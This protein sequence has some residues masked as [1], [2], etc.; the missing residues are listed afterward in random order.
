MT[1]NNET[2]F[3]IDKRT[4]VAINRMCTNLTGGTVLSTTNI[5]DGQNISFVDRI[6]YNEFFGMTLY[7]DIYHRA[8][9]YM[10]YIVKNHIFI[11]GNK[12]TGLACALTFLQ[13]NGFQI[14]PLDDDSVFDFVIVVA[15]GPNDADQQIP[16]I[17]DW[18]KS[19]CVPL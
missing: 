12:R 8:A 17:A 2:I 10:F 16:K 6:F 11:D 18:L 4:V 1:Q 13:W 3:F 15:S 14:D 7:P 5:R 9:A 19:L